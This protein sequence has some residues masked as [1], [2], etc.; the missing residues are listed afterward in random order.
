MRLEAAR[1]KQTG[2]TKTIN[3]WTEVADSE[4]LPGHGHGSLKN[5]GK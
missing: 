5:R 2:L 4:I 3:H 1:P